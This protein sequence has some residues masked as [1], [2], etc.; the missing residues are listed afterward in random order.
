MCKC[1]CY[2]AV[3]TSAMLCMLSY[4]VVVVR[5]SRA[6]SPGCYSATARTAC[7]CMHA[8]QSELCM[9]TPMSGCRDVL[10]S[11]MCIDIGLCKPCCC[12]PATACT[13]KASYGT[14]AN[15]EPRQWTFQCTS[16]PVAV[17]VALA[18]DARLH[19]RTAA[20]YADAVVVVLQGGKQIT[21]AAAAAAGVAT[22]MI[23][24]ACTVL[25][26]CLL[27]IHVYRMLHSCLHS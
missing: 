8:K 22:I 12:A 18:N 19:K 6:G 13:H 16:T 21:A 1:R 24:S 26:T 9:Q 14:Y 25:H 4:G 17:P 10:T 2:A 3:C 11:N 20:H 27:L 15:E 5:L 23:C 7:R